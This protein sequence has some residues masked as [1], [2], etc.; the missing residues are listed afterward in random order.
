MAIKPNYYETL[1]VVRPDL[2]EEDLA[3]IQQKLNDA[4]AAH[5]GEIIKSDK[6]GQRELAYEI[7]DHKRGIYHILISKALPGV[8]A[9]L[10]K[11]LRFYNNDVLRFMTVAIT[12]D[13]A[14]REKAAPE[15]KEEAET[16]ETEA[17]TEGAE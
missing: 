2:A 11:H 12:E 9:D 17:E 8:V 7:Q 6:W 3:K 14:N 13:A 1:Y 16:S 10:E 4:I 15:N 5:E